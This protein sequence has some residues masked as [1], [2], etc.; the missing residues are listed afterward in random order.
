MARVQFVDRM[1]QRNACGT[2][3]S[4]NLDK[5][6][7][8]FFAH[9]SHRLA[10]PRNVVAK[11]ALHPPAL[12]RQHFLKRDAV[13]LS[14]LV[15]SGCSAFRF[16]SA[17]S[18]QV[19][20]PVIGDPTNSGGQHGQE[21]EEGEEGEERSEEDCQEDQEGFQEEEVTRL[22]KNAGG[23]MPA[24]H[25]SHQDV[26]FSKRIPNRT[27]LVDERGCRRD[28]RS[29]GRIA[30]SDGV[31]SFRKTVRQKNQ[32]GYAGIL[33]SVRS[34]C[35]AIPAAAFAEMEFAP[36][37]FADALVLHVGAVLPRQ[38][39]PRRSHSTFDR[40]VRSGTACAGPGA[41]GRQA[42]RGHLWS[43]EPAA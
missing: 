38:D 31:R 10:S 8:R 29:N 27:A 30:V 4:F 9:F 11:R 3:V 2:G 17:R 5:C 6:R 20:S 23:L 33:Q 35:S 21:S 40:R 37:V 24:R 28:I 26:C 32:H 7:R 12:S 41:T 19:V 42:S 1:N 22:T 15:Y 16:P 18:D 43:S 13:F 25:L 36:D 14:V 34:S 39:D